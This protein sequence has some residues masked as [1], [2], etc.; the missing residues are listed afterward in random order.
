MPIVAVDV[1]YE[2]PKAY[3]AAIA[4]DAWSASTPFF[5]SVTTIDSVAAYVP[6][7]FYER[8]MPCVLAALRRLDFA[9]TLVVVD[10]YVDLGIEPGLGR[11]IYNALEPKVPVIG[12]A[13]SAFVHAKPALVLRPGSAR[14]LYVT[15]THDLDAAVEGVLAMHG[16]HRI[17]TLLARVDRLA[18]GVVDE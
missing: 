8:E 4:F 1:H 9:P 6:G 10:G 15:A 14:P 18:R 3:A 16:A 11:H 2:D 5:E 17:P 7:R 13:K 12:V